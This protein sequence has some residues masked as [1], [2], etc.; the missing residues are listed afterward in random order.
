MSFFEFFYALVEWATLNFNGTR[1]KLTFDLT[2]H[3][4]KNP[5]VGEGVAADGHSNVGVVKS[6]ECG[7][8]GRQVCA[9]WLKNKSGSKSV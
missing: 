3:S 5:Q 2:Q 7:E 1:A 4:G 8:P 6:D 9:Y